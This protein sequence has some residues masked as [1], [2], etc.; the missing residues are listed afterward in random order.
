MLQVVE[1]WVGFLPQQKL[2]GDDDPLFPASRVEL[3]VTRHFEAT[4]IDRRAW[5]TVSPIRAVFKQAFEAAGLPYFNPHSFRRTL[6]QLGE[7]MCK[8]PE[9]FNVWGQNLGHDGVL[10][11]FY[12]Y[13]RV[14]DR[15]QGESIKGLAQS[16]PIAGGHAEL[17]EALVKAMRQGGLVVSQGRTGQQSGP[18]SGRL[19]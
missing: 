7:T 4:S 18:Q 3:G 17:A 2:W 5:S 15:R 19:Q 16:Q 10:A 9:Q 14:A 11:T 6:A 13:G 8:T 1:D 12:S